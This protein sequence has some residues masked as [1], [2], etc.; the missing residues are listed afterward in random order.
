MP[1]IDMS[2][3]I[4]DP[5]LNELVVLIRRVETIGTNGRNAITE[6]LYN[7][8]AV[9][10]PGTQP[11]FLRTPDGQALP[12]TITVHTTSILQGPALGMQ[13]DIIQWNGVNYVVRVIYDFS[14]YGSGFSSAMCEAV[15]LVGQPITS[16][17]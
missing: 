5:D 11:G 16:T 14:S 2:D 6:T 7:I 10:T 15:S 1:T 8:G 12:N 4:N 17:P 9:V 3:I 13:P